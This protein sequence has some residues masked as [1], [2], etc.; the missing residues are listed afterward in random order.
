MGIQSTGIDYFV[1]GGQG[2]GGAIKSYTQKSEKKDSLLARNRP[3]VQRNV[4]AES[5]AVQK[6]GGI[7]TRV[8]QCAV[9]I[10]HI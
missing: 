6:I 9:M 5:Q 7:S 3:I 1:N 4:S 10:D 8:P 2:H